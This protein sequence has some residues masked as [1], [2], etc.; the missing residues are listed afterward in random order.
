[1]NIVDNIEEDSNQYKDE[2]NNISNK[3]KQKLNVASPTLLKTGAMGNLINLITHA[4]LDNK[5]YLNQ[6]VK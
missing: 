3:L 1:M 4:K 5:V 2:L 6:I